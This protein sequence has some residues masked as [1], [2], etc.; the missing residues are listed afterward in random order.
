MMSAEEERFELPV[1]FT[2]A[3]FK[4]AALDHSAT[5]PKDEDV[6]GI[7]GSNQGASSAAVSV[8]RERGALAGALALDPVETALAAALTAAAAAGRFDV[9]AQ[10]AKGLEARRL[11]HSANVVSIESAK[12]QR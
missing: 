3:V 8:P 4:T 2:T 11:P 7:A 1:A 9:V 5:P 10:L 12:R 6:A